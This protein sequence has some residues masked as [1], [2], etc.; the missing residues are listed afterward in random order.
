VDARVQTLSRPD[1]SFKL[2][3]V[4]EADLPLGNLE[5]A[6]S[7]WQRVD[8]SPLR[9]HLEHLAQAGQDVVDGLR[10]LVLEVGLELLHVGIPD[11]VQAP[12]AEPGLEVLV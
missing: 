9:C 2:V 1:E 3:R 4:V 12:L 6:H 7:T 10:A 5:Q 11:L 8:H